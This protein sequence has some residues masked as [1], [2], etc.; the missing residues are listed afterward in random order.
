M[1]GGQSGIGIL[2]MRSAGKT[3]EI[4]DSAVS[5]EKGEGIGEREGVFAI[6]E[7]MPQCT[8]RMPVPHALL[9][10]AMIIGLLG[11]RLWVWARRRR[12]RG[13]FGGG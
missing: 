7:V 13:L 5:L 12:R 4:Q 8:G 1:G 9:A 3:R 6:P 2:P 10:E 11:R